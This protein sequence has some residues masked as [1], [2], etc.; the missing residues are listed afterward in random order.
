MRLYSSL[1][2]YFGQINDDDG[3]DD[4]TNVLIADD[5]MYNLIHRNKVANNSKVQNSILTVT[6]PVSSVSLTTYVHLWMII[7]WFSGHSDM[8]RRI[9]LM[10]A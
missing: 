2:L 7:V 4:D 9:S 5:F 1:L 6:L 3:G 8:N 10:G